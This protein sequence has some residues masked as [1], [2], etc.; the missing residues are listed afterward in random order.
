MSA[1]AAAAGPHEPAT[2]QAMYLSDSENSPL[3][4]HRY[5]TLPGKRPAA[6]H[7]SPGRN[8]KRADATISGAKHRE[9]DVPLDQSNQKAI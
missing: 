3:I 8:H 6:K 5:R 9:V 4:Q 1:A 2:V 7:Q